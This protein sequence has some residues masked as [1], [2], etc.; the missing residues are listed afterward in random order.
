MKC[1]KCNGKGYYRVNDS[2]LHCWECRCI[3]KRSEMEELAALRKRVEEIEGSSRRW[4]AL[5]HSYQKSGI[6]VDEVRETADQL[7][8]DF[9]HLYNEHLI[10]AFKSPSPEQG[11]QG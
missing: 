9:I 10:D 4:L 1:P 3:A 11:G 2:D 6:R 7:L 8:E 5:V